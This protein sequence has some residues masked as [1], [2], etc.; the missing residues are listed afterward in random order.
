MQPEAKLFALLKEAGE[1]EGLSED[2]FAGVG[3]V[4]VFEHLAKSL[5][6]EANYVSVDMVAVAEEEA[7]YRADPQLSEREVDQLLELFRAD[8]EVFYEETTDMTDLRGLIEEL[9]EAEDRVMQ[10][11]QDLARQRLQLADLHEG[12]GAVRQELIE[13][14]QGLARSNHVLQDRVAGAQARSVAESRAAQG[15]QECARQ[16]QELLHV[17][18]EA[19]LLLAQPLDELRKVETATTSEV[20]RAKEQL[21]PAQLSRLLAAQQEA[22]GA[23][24]DTPFGP[25]GT[26]LLTGL[27]PEQYAATLAEAAR[28]GADG[29]ELRDQRERSLAELAGL[30]KQVELLEQLARGGGGSALGGWQRQVLAEPD[31]EAR[32]AAQ[33]AEAKEQLRSVLDGEE[34]QSLLDTAASSATAQVKRALWLVHHQQL[35]YTSAL[36]KQLAEVLMQEWARTELVQTL[37]DEERRSLHDIYFTL[38]SVRDELQ[39]AASAA[40]A[41]AEAARSV[42]ASAQGAA[43]V[44]NDRGPQAL[45]AG[46]PVLC[47]TFALLDAQ[48]QQLQAVQ[49]GEQSADAVSSA[50]ASSSPLGL[51]GG[52]GGGGGGGMGNAFLDSVMSDPSHRTVTQLAAEYEALGSLVGRARQQLSDRLGGQLGQLVAEGQARVDELRTLLG[53]PAPGPSPAPSPLPASSLSG[54]G[55]GAVSGSAFASASALSAASSAAGAGAAAAPWPVLRDQA[56][57]AELTGLMKV[58]G[59]VTARIQN[60]VNRQNMLVADQKRQHEKSRTERAVLSTFWTHPEALL[61]AVQGLRNRL[62]ALVAAS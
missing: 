61:E 16:M 34:R 9:A 35:G 7:R 52:G 58:T 18:P 10:K 43:A 14:E 25:S 3:H 4:P 42:A 26:R 31:A 19:C 51:G 13:A 21:R 12:S 30:R 1:A 53:A 20:T 24:P 11:D 39:R 41:D 45:L 2:A 17:S 56:L 6:V 49:G 15:M 23:L 33:V 55:G 38:E 8:P 60:Y 29:R 28:L 44:A 57:E 46:E 48:R 50:A 47:A 22:Q 62:A 36:H 27:E 32:L 54:A 5:T 37:R 59:D 40:D